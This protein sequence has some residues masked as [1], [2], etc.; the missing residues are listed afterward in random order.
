MQ[1]GYFRPPSTRRHLSARALAPRAQLFDSPRELQ[2]LNGLREGVGGSG[3]TV[4]ACSRRR[5]GALPHP[6]RAA[7]Q[8]GERGRRARLLPAATSALQPPRPAAPGRVAGGSRAAAGA[9]GAGGADE[10]VSRAARR[11]AHYNALSARP[12]IVN[13]ILQH[14][15]IVCQC[16]FF[17]C[18]ASL[19]RAPT[20]LYLCTPFP[21]PASR[22][23][24]VARV[25]S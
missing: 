11:S 17:H 15:C 24:H 3:N 5:R 18:L 7:I 25:F 21:F 16:A 4:G 20:A 2:I 10:P 22:P 19:L 9:A 23:R 8:P 14:H 6:R 1:D 13:P 12:A